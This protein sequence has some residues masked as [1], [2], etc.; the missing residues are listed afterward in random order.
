MTTEKKEDYKGEE[1]YFCGEP[2]AGKYCSKQCKKYAE[3]G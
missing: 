3:N 1:C 2:C